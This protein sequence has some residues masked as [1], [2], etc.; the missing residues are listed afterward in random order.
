M[1]SPFG[2][3]GQQGR[4]S[5]GRSQPPQQPPTPP[6][7]KPYQPTPEEQ[8]YLQECGQAITQGCGAATDAAAA[9]NGQEYLA[10]ANGVKALTQ[11]YAEIKTGGKAS[12]GHQ[13]G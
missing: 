12:T 5:A 8:A 1:S 3:Q 6:A 9:G 13:G 10:F 2:D 7:P 4:Q 11:A